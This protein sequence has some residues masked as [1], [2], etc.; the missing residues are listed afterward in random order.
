MTINLQKLKIEIDQY[1]NQLFP[2]EIRNPY[3]IG[4]VF[5]I[6]IFI[7][8]SIFSSKSEDPSNFEPT[9]MDTF[10]PHGH[11]LVNINVVNSESLDSIIG[12]KAVVDVYVPAP[13]GKAPKLL[14]RKARVLR[15]PLNPNHYALLV[16]EDWTSKI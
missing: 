1:M 3:T 12:E 4:F 2:P 7:G 14:L 5:I 8:Y 11:N 15:A 10:I 6:F 9:S 16:P 13:K